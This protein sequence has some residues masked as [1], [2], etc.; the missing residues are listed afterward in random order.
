MNNDRKISIIGGA[1][2]VGFPL[3]LVL[4]SKGFRINLIDKNMANLNKI[5][6]GTIPFMEIGAKKMLKN[7]LKKKRIFTYR[8][9]EQIKKSKFVIICIGT[10]IDNNLKPKLKEFI[11]FFKFLKKF[12]NKSQIIIIRS[13]IYPG[14]FHKVYKILK[15]KNKNMVYCPERIVQGKLIEELPKL[16]QIVAGSN[17]FAINKTSDLFKKVTFKIIKTTVLEAEL[18]KLFTNANRYINFSIAN[19][20]FMIC[21]ENNIDYNKLRAI[22][23]DGYERNLNLS[24]AGFSAGPCLLKDTMQLSSF[25]NYKFSLGHTALSINE[26]IP[27]FILN[28]LKREH[29]LK[30]K[31]V[32]VLG[33][34][35]KAETDDLRDSLAI[36]LVKLLKLSKI[37]VLQSDEY[38]SSTHTVQAEYLIKNSDIIIIAAPHTKYK[39]FKIAK[40][41]TVVDI[42]G[43][44]KNI[45]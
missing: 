35:F 41:K 34:A 18:I 40:H 6:S 33:L 26:G 30:K 5:K 32:G 17:K 36:K 11:N 19:Q 28:K 37:K 29:N 4:A 1:G 10:P 24:S 44:R 45:L 3:G 38:Y 8:S 42:W 21:K 23:R 31:I 39:R 7:C 14:I 13:S 16:P 25:Y 43:I 9:Y 22:M 2:H 27:K 20:F 12:I 15:V